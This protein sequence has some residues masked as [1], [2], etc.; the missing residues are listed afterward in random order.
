MRKVNAA[1][2]KSMGI[3][4]P[5]IRVTNTVVKMAA[6]LKCISGSVPECVSTYYCIVI[7]LVVCLLNP[8]VSINLTIHLPDSTRMFSTYGIRE[9][10][11]I[12]ETIVGADY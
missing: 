7:V 8:L 4:Y 1:I 5:Y 9:L 6:Y 3:A 12:I 11:I 10:M 2:G